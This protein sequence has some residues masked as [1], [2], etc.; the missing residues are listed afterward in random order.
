MPDQLFATFDDRAFASASIGQVHAA[1]LFDGT[2]V[3]VKIQHPDIE[4]KIRSDLDILDSLAHLAERH[5]EE[6]SLFRPVALVAQFRRILMHELDFSREARNLK[7]LRANFSDDDRVVFPAP[8]AE[9]SGRR[10]LTMK[11]LDG[12]SLSDPRALKELG[13]DPTELAHRG[14]SLYMEMVFRDGFFHADPHPGNILVLP[15]NVIGLLDAGMV[16]IMGSE[17]RRQFGGLIQGIVTSDSELLLHQILQIGSAPETL[18]SECLHVDVAEFVAD[19]MGVSVEQL[20]LSEALSN[21][22][23]LVR[24]HRI[25]LPP[26]VAMLIKLLVMLE[27]TARLLSPDFSLAEIAERHYRSLMLRSYSP[28]ELASR[29]RRSIRDWDVVIDRLPNDISDVI[30]RVSRGSFDVHLQHRRLATTVNRLIYGV[31]AASLIVSAAL[32]AVSHVPPIVLGTSLYS[33][34]CASMALILAVRLLRAIE[35]SGG[36]GRPGERGD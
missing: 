13:H 19:H 3:V 9:L 32:L 15:N 4:D 6:L 5:S 8:F 34:V 1:T 11:R 2:R 22:S 30:D 24:K 36:L 26:D 27:G 10:V 25:H 14:A 21:F 31:L 18:D 17:R 23:S 29:L 12:D 33:L 28:T 7:H 16:G 35:W 20:D